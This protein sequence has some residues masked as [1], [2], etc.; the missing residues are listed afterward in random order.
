M[1]PKAQIP[2]VEA[3]KVSKLEK[4]LPLWVEGH[5]VPEPQKGGQSHS[6]TECEDTIKAGHQ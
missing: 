6:V 3:P 5:A 1:P 4:L 2:P